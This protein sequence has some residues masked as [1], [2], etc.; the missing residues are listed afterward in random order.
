MKVPEKEYRKQSRGKSHEPEEE[1]DD[2]SH[3]TVDSYVVVDD[4]T[5]ANGEQ[6]QQLPGTGG[7]PT[8]TA[9]EG[10]VWMRKLVFRGQLTAH[11]AFSSPGI[12][13]VLI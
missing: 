3:D 7:S 4:P 11:T 6:D 5:T 12:F 2:S 10:Y 13:T 9:A 1:E 8:A